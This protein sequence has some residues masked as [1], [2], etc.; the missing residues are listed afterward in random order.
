MA[1]R[2]LSAPSEFEDDPVKGSRF[3]AR[4]A[5]AADEPSALA[6][7]A[8]A[9]R[10]WPD[11]SHHC[12]AYRLRSGGHRSADDGEPGGSAGRPILAQIEGHDVHDVVVVVARWFGGT[13]LGVGGL[14]RAYGGCAGR[15]L[16][17]APF[18][19][20][21][22][23]VRLLVEHAYDDTGSVQAVVAARGLAVVDTAWAEAVRLRLEVPEP[24]RADVERALADATR[25]RATVKGPADD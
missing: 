14:I 15:A 19:E 20:V 7:V 2:T 25:G 21:V 4:V 24:D 23:T 17:R 6:E 12:W 13:K 10:R 5:P 18:V 22:P 3:V 8:E 11:A 9:R 1:Y 16:D